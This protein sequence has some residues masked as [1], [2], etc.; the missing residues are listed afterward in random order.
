[1]PPVEIVLDPHRHAGL[2]AMPSRVLMVSVGEQV[3]TWHRAGQDEAEHIRD[4][5]LEHGTRVIVRR[6]DSAGICDVSALYRRAAA[7]AGVFELM[8]QDLGR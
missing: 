4:L 6:F 7:E 1:M 2:S 5:L 8:S 3:S